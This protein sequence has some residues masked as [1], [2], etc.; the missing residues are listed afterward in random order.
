MDF[1]P[2]RP[3]WIFSR[4]VMRSRHRERI[5]T[6]LEFVRRFFPEIESCSVRVGLALKP[7]VLGWG[8][9]DPERPG[10]WVR[11]RRL[12]YFT[13]A[14]EFTHLLQAKKL[15][16]RGERA[17]DLWAMARSPLLIDSSPGYLKLPQVLRGRRGLDLDTANLLHRIA[18]DAI[19]GRDRGER[20]YLQRFERDVAR[21]LEGRHA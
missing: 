7:G 4:L 6:R 20:A 8:S 1:G 12:E 13:I 19:E 17:C 3:R 5:V 9:L 14:H 2:E 15:V 11:P 16:P 10:V 21:A 18:R